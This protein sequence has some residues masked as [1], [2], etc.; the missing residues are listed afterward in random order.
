MKNEKIRQAYDTLNPSVDQKLRMLDALMESVPEE[1]PK[2]KP[3]YTARHVEASRWSAIP[4]AVCCLAVLLLASFV[5][6]RLPVTTPEQKETLEPSQVQTDPT[7]TQEPTQETTGETVEETQQELYMET[8]GPFG[9]GDYQDYVNWLRQYTDVSRNNTK[10]Y[11]WLDV[12]G[13]GIRDLLMG[14]EAGGIQEVITQKD[15]VLSLLF[16]VGRECIP[17]ENGIMLSMN[18]VDGYHVIFRLDGDEYTVVETLWYDQ[19]R[20]SW[21]RYRS[22]TGVKETIT[23]QRVKDILASYVPVE[24]DMRNLNVF[25]VE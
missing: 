22:D 7:E 10:Y 25:S 20:G 19:A 6:Q 2:S 17:C 11:A 5:L 8:E 3:L 15:G 13:D 16:T 18:D 1:P 12:N 9:P 21:F 24:L 4:A 14:N 23:N